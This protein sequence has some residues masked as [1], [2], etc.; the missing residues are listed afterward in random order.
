MIGAEVKRIANGI[1]LGRFPISQP[2][3]FV[4]PSSIEV[5]VHTKKKSIE[6]AIESQLYM[7]T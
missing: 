5:V 6:V 2:I 1:S 4:F 3:I 7:I